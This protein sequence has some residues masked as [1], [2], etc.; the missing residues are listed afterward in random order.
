MLERSLFSLICTVRLV[1]PLPKP[2]LSS[3]TLRIALPAS[4]QEDSPGQDEADAL[5]L[6]ELLD[7]CIPVVYGATMRYSSSFGVQQV[8]AALTTGLSL[9][10]TV[11]R[12]CVSTT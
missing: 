1:A 11:R 10:K 8:Q 9:R 6:Q 7:T 3:L 2:H 5:Q 4:V 12:L